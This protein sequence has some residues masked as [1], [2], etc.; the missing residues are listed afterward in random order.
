MS[1][2][3]SASNAA[4]PAK[5]GSAEPSAASKRLAKKLGLRFV[6]V[7]DL[8]IVRR[9]QGSGFGYAGR[10]GRRIGNKLVTRRLD[11][12]AVPPASV[13]G[14]EIGETVIPALSLS[15][16]VTETSLTSRPA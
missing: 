3:R 9:R 11:R 1:A 10:N 5:P 13:V 7:D 2:S 4:N 14:P 12:L 6:R 15:V 8:S 16:F